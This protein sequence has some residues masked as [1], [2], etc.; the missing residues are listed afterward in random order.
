M[1]LP[2]KFFLLLLLVTVVTLLGSADAARGNRRNKSSCKYKRKGVDG[3]C[4]VAT[5]K[6]QVTFAL[7]ARKSSPKCEPTKVVSL[8]CDDFS[9]S[10][11]QKGRKMAMKKRCKYVRNRTEKPKCDLATNTKTIVRNLRVTEGVPPP[12]NCPL[13][14]TIKKRCGRGGRK[15]NKRRNKNNGA[16]NGKQ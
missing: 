11:K 10:K 7:K 1:R 5:N 8:D 2:Q 14:K 3:A 16:R 6:K 12:D 13:V 4:D 15:G 9:A